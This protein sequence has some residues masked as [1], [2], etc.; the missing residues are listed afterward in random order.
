LSLNEW[1]NTWNLHIIE[2]CRERFLS[3]AL[4]SVKIVNAKEK[5]A[6]AV[7]R[8]EPEAACMVCGG[9]ALA[10]LIRTAFSPARARPRSSAA[11]AV[12]H[13]WPA[14]LTGRGQSV[15]LPFAEFG[16]ALDRNLRCMLGWNIVVH[17]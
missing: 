13:G 6:E 11:S 4:R 17:L 7:Y 5:I 16:S 10:S 1:L 14:S 8:V 3:L 9:G 2:S 15:Q 12:L